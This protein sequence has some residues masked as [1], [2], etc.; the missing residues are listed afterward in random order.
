MPN[1]TKSIFLDVDSTI[2]ENNLRFMD[3]SE[4]ELGK[5]FTTPGYASKIIQP[6]PGFCVKTKEVGSGTKVFVNVCQTDAIPPPKDISVKELEE[7]MESD[8]P[9]DYKV[10]MSLGEIRTEPDKKGQDAK[11]CD[12]AI[13]PAFLKKVAENPAFKSF[14]L[15]VVFQGIED[16]YNLSCEDE[17][18]PLLNRKTFG[19]LQTHRIQQREIDQKMAESTQKSLMSEVGGSAEPKKVVIET[20]SNT[21]TIT[22][23]PEFRLYKKKTGQNCLYGEFKLP[24]VISAQEVDLD[25]GEDR[26]LLES[27]TRNYLLDIFVPY[28]VKQKNCSSSFDKSTKILTV[29][30]PL[31]GG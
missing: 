31:V 30:M 17:K 3:S 20:L 1:N 24:D 22:K 13:H 16:K 19:K 29:T 8:E 15:A 6:T 28:I 25:I 21:E 23:T 26:I 9:G 27:K 5:F 7:L 11:V 14:F 12:V 4:E 18:T 10:P 2:I